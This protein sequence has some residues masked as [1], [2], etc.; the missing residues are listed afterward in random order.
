MKS[1]ALSTVVFLPKICVDTPV[2][3]SFNMK[4]QQVRKHTVKTTYFYSSN[5]GENANVFLQYDFVKMLIF[6]AFL[7][8][9][10]FFH[11]IMLKY[12]KHRWTGELTFFQKKSKTEFPNSVWWSNTKKHQL[13]VKKNN[14][15]HVFISDSLWYFRSFHFF[16]FYSKI[17]Q[18]KCGSKQ[19]CLEGK[20]QELHFFVNFWEFSRSLKKPHCWETIQSHQKW[21]K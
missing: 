13:F 18:K 7:V 8:F 12:A 14:E 17:L 9:L 15:F 10:L 1:G 19:Y 21:M 3:C 5:F 16:S 11:K 6:K 20:S 2:Q 4:N